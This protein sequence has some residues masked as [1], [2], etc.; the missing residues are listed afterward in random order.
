MRQLYLRRDGEESELHNNLNE[1]LLLHPDIRHALLLSFLY[2]ALP[3]DTRNG[4]EKESEWEEEEEE[5]HEDDRFRPP[6]RLPLSGCM[7]DRDRLRG[8]KLEMHRKSVECVL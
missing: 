8:G 1:F 7:I 5:E 6:F 2:N 4:R 3:H